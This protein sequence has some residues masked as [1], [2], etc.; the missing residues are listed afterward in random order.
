MSHLCFILAFFPQVWYVL[1]IITGNRRTV[2]HSGSNWQTCSEWMTVFMGMFGH[3]SQK[4]GPWGILLVRWLTVFSLQGMRVRPLVRELRFHM[5]LAKAKKRSGGVVL[6]SF[7]SLMSHFICIPKTTS[8][9]T[10]RTQ[11]LVWN[12]LV[13][14]TLLTIFRRPPPGCVIA[15]SNSADSTCPVVSN[16]GIKI[17]ALP[18]M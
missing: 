18:C 8:Q 6:Q 2:T 13:Q 12:S 9:R 17:Q 5:P 14:L 4:M 1:T 10:P 7:S 11:S 15:T 16:C 3:L